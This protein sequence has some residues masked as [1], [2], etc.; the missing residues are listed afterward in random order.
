MAETKIK[1][2]QVDIVTAINGMIEA[3]SA[4]DYTLCLRAP[5][6]GV[7]VRLTAESTNSEAAG[8][9]QIKINEAS[10]TFAGGA[11]VLAGDT[12]VTDTISAGGVFAIDDTIKLTVI[13]PSS[14]DDLSFTL[15][16][17]R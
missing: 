15:E 8:T 10:V 12:E 5:I 16:Y 9:L 14:L 6:A 1:D 11:F 7:L 2:D 17:D 13:G 4:K 3:P